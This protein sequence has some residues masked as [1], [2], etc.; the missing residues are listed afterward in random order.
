MQISKAHAEWLKQHAEVGPDN[1]AR[2]KT[3]NCKI[4]LRIIGR[5][6]WIKPLT[7]GFGSVEK[8][9]HPYC[10]TCVPDPQFPKYGEP[11]YDDELIE[12]P[13]VLVYQKQ[14]AT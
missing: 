5:S 9:A 2:C 11:I 14:P 6:I 8:V 13:I 1:I 3:S 4:K 12:R 10:P 7:G